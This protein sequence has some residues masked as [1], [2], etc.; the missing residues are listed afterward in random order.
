MKNFLYSRAQIELEVTSENRLV[1]KG[2]QDEMN[3]L[4]DYVNQELWF[5]RVKKILDVL[6]K[7]TPWLDLPSWC[8]LNQK[9]MDKEMKEYGGSLSYTWNSYLKS[10]LFQN[11]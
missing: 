9:K 5:F 8:L 3:I 11:V 6:V 10:Q 2:I 7:S 4:Y 1:D